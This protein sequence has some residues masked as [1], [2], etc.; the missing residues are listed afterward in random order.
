MIFALEMTIF[1]TLPH[2]SSIV[3]ASKSIKMLLLK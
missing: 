1:V 2:I 3:L